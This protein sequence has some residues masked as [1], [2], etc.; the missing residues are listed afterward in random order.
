MSEITVYTNEIVVGAT[1]KYI[2]W[3]ITLADL[4]T[5]RPLA[6]CT[7]RLQAHSET[8]PDKDIDAAAVVVD[9]GTSLVRVYEAGGLISVADLGAHPVARYVGRA[10]I[11]DASAK[12]D[13]TPQFEFNFVPPPIAP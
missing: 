8:L 6:G 5:P 7:V 9:S 12:V 10:Q 1:G 4:V 3:N 11:T 13:Y 2:E